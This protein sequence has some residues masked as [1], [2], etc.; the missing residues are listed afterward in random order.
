MKKNFLNKIATLLVSRHKERLTELAIVLP[1]RRSSLFLTKE[2]SKIIPK[3]IWLPK[4]YS[5]DDFV[6]DINKLKAAN[7]LELFFELYKSYKKK[8]SNPHSIERCYKWASALIDDFNEIDKA[9]VDQSKLFSYLSDV[10]RIENWFLDTSKNSNEINEYVDFFNQLPLIYEDLHKSLISKNIAYSGLAQRTLVDNLERIHDWLDYNKKNHIL[11]IGLDALSVSQEKI[12]DYLLKREICDILWDADEYFVSNSLQES[13]KFLRKYKEKWPKTLDNIDNDFLNSKKDI[14]IIGTTKNVSQAKL[15]GQMLS[16]IKADEENLQ[17]TAIILPNENLLLSVLESI[18]KNIKNINIT[19]GYKVVHHPI[20]AILFDVINLYINSKYT[21]IN[22]ETILKQFLKSDLINIVHNPYFELL[23][24]SNNLDIIDLRDYLNNYNFSYIDFNYIHSYFKNSSNKLF[25][26]IFSNN[27]KTGIELLYLFQ[28]IINELLQILYNEPDEIGVLEQ[29]CLYFIEDHVNQMMMFLKT[30]DENINSKVLHKLFYRVLNSIKLNFS[31]EPLRG[32]QIMG[33][34]EAR[35]VDFENIFILSA[36]ESELPPSSHSNSFLPF[37]I[38]KQFKIRTYLDVDAIYANQFFNLIKRPSNTT[39]LYNQ[40]LSFSSSG[41]KSRFLNQLLYEIKPL[42]NPNI[43]IS[44]KIHSAEFALND[45]KMETVLRNKDL[46]VINRLQKLAKGGFSPSTINLYNYCKKQFYFEKILNIKTEYNNNESIDKSTIGS[47]IHE[48]LQN[49]YSPYLKIDLN[50]K[51]ICQILK[52]I[53]KEV[54]K[55]LNA[56]NLSNLDKGKNL[57]AVDAIKKIIRN[58]VNSELESINRGNNIRIEMLEYQMPIQR[59]KIFKYINKE[60][61]ELDLNLKGHI[62]RVD[63]FNGEYRIIDYKTGFVSSL[64]L[65]INSLDSITSKPK[66][67]QLLLY[68]WLFTKQSNLK[69]I[70][71]K[72]GVINLKGN[73]F[74]FQSCQINNQFYISKQILKDFENELE[75]IFIDMFSLHVGFEHQERVEKCRF[76]D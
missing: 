44:E 26:T 76:C 6:F 7:N 49:L 5:I 68:V 48:V 13:G 63:I 59:F 39:I 56:Y 23:L 9:Y 3:P 40:D 35:T 66:L 19:M 54:F 71:I 22:S 60:L 20:C 33:L 4:F 38:K 64:D 72:S 53:D 10:K 25:D 46:Y 16:K 18:P 51:I 17:E 11:F 12:I 57:L 32:I 34:L 30:T 70:P 21:I 37:D 24:E 69:N 31:G 43:T 8:V 61:P 75:K 29:E 36:N 15:L 67:V 58:F 41:E 47:I 28:I 52:S 27:L 2:I 62:D 45:G 55:T 42:G 73:N 65:K 50:K 74:Q 14:R 1:S